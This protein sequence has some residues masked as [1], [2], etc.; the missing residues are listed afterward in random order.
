MEHWIVLPPRDWSYLKGDVRMSL[1]SGGTRS[2]QFGPLLLGTLRPSRMHLRPLRLKAF[3]RR[4]REDL[5]E[6]AKKTKKAALKGGWLT[7]LGHCI[8][9]LNSMPR[10]SLAAMVAGISRSAIRIFICP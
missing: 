6:G 10:W 1:H 5:T 7:T 3:D 2:G 9:S 8:G 4:V